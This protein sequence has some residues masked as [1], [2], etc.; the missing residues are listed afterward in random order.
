M[1]LVAEALL[2]GLAGW[3]VASLLVNES[4]P[5]HIFR[6]LR[7]VLGFTHGDDGAVIAW[8]DKFLPNLLSCVWCL[9]PWVAAAMWGLW[10]ISEPAVIILAASSILLM[11]E[12]WNNP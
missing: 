7:S 4:G 8:P 2:I 10:Q 12:R 1:E 6:N 11:A 9:S 3:R 5:F